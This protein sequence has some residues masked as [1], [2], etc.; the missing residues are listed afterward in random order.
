MAI[1]GPG[2]QCAYS[3]GVQ[4]ENGT[5]CRADFLNDCLVLVKGACAAVPEGNGY[6]ERFALSRCRTE[7]IAKVKK[8]LLRSPETTFHRQPVLLVGNLI[9]RIEVAGNAP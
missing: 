9:A 6:G 2:K 4:H 3:G 7:Q 1:E 8:V 5:S